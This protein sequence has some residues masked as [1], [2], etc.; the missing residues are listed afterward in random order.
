MILPPSHFLFQLEKN[1]SCLSFPFRLVSLS[2]VT[3]PDFPKGT[4]K[5]GGARCSADND[6]PLAFLLSQKRGSSPR[7]QDIWWMSVM[8]R[9]K[10][11]VDLSGTYISPAFDSVCTFTYCCCICKPSCSYFAHMPSRAKRCG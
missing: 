3:R 9:P 5:R 2:K 6:N 8:H 11:S 10:R 1:F 7:V 4:W